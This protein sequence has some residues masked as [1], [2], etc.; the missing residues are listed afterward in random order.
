MKVLIVDDYAYNR[1]LLGFI[2][3]ECGYDYDFA[4]NGEVG[5][6]KW[7]TDESIDIVLMDVNMPVMDGYE[8]TRQIKASSNERF[9]PIIFVTALD[10]DK[11][12]AQGL[13]AGG[14]DF[15]GKPINEKVLLAKLNAHSRTLEYY[16]QIQEK[17][18]QLEYHRLVMDRE[19]SIVDHVFRN[20]LSRLDFHC[21]SIRYHVSPMSMFNG[22][23]L[24]VAPSPCGGLYVL[25]G[26]FTG[27]GL[28]AAIGCL[29]V[30]DIFY[31]MTAKRAS[32]STMAR[33]I[34]QRL[35]ELLPDNMFCCAAIL[36]LNAGGDR[37][38]IWSGGIND[39]IF[40][41]KSGIICDK[42]ASQHMPLGILAD[43][44]FDDAVE[45]I[46][47][48]KG[49]HI[50]VYTDGVIEAGNPAGELYGEE[51]FEAL[52]DQSHGNRVQQIVDSVASFTNGAEQD[53]DISLVELVC[54]PVEHFASDGSLY[55][56]A[57]SSREMLPWEFSLHLTPKYLRRPN[58]AHELLEQIASVQSVGGHR[59]TLFTLLSEFLS[60]ALE[61]GILGLDSQLKLEPDGFFTYYQERE[62]RL[63]NLDSGQISLLVTVRPAE[64]DY[65][66][67]LIL[68]M[69]D[70][71]SGFDHGKVLQGLKSSDDSLMFGRGVELALSLCESVEYSNQGRT[72]TAVYVLD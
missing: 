24:L 33:E 40:T 29:P 48:P 32:I 62:Q 65:C 50:Y 1:E 59:D 31:A 5:V 43:G 35:L 41:D 37:L 7:L 63:A 34:N 45:I 30:S 55:Q 66:A 54:Q 27:H 70:S 21:P 64:D 8:A 58:L 72:V 53:D 61:H 20:G 46:A 39:L 44:E 28:S 3:L 9:T 67:R 6:E 26:D 47:P 19:H 12:L 49:T 22:D 10:D 36:E 68:V 69:T 51:R 52:F 2:L 38:N 23:L 18:Q 17:N 42:F 15:V 57:A 13:E 56:T 4:E 11:T 60:N 25:L 14:D 16:R 71:G